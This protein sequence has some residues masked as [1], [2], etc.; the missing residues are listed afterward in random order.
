VTIETGATL[1]NDGT[2]SLKGGFT[3]NG[4]AS[5]GSGTFVFNGTAAQSIAGTS[6]SAF[7]DLTINNSSGVSLA[8]SAR[9]EG[10]LT[11]TDGL[12]GIGT[13][14]LVFG[15]AAT[16]VA[17]TPAASN[18]ILAD[19]TGEVR[20]EFA[21]GT[22]ANPDLFLFPVGSDDG[23]A[24]Y[25]PISIDFT[26]GDFTAAYTGVNV[27]ATKEPNNN[28]ADN[29]LERYWSISNS[30]ITNY[31]YDLLAQYEDADIAG[32]EADISGA[33]YTGTDWLIVDP[34]T[35]A[36]NTFE[37]SGLTEDGNITGVEF[38]ILSQLKVFAQGPYNAGAGEMSTA[39][40]SYI[41]LACSTAYSNIGYTGPEAVAA[42]PNADVVDWILIE[43]RDATNA[44][45]ANSG[46]IVETVAGFLLKS[47]LI[48]GLDGS[49]PISFKNAVSNDAF[50]VVHHRNHLP[51]MTAA[52]PTESFGNYIYDFT[53]SDAKAYGTDA[54]KLIGST[55]SVYGMYA[56][57]GN[58]NGVVDVTDYSVF[59][60]INFG[61]S[62]GYFNGDFNMN[63]VVDITD[64]STM[65]ALSFGRAKLYP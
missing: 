7:E 35:T 49:S 8:A 62:G 19:N 18:M 30:G 3:N 38:K 54:M 42:I 15:I 1:D 55:P 36:T 48:V 34:V 11:L 46:T 56:G 9:V 24:E 23:T 53:D 26:T 6:A 39:L 17:G 5:L 43:L 20:K 16:A 52:S 51:V 25:S 47:G 29:Y 32:T 22:T 12:F 64:Y 58:G 33:L 50:F 31:A 59:W 60:A 40:N 21:N 61:Q 27:T 28:S 63:G 37:G 10:T 4:T 45:S 65:W 41:P 13:N 14:N 2:V 44:A 57:D